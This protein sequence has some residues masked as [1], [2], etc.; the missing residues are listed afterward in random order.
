V[1][2]AGGLRRSGSNDIPY[3]KACIWGRTKL[4][5]RYAA[6]VV[7]KQHGFQDVDVALI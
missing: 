6:D 4:L 7:M 5:Y 1:K 2:A 3:V